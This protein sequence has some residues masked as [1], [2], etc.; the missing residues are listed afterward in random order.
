MQGSPEEYTDKGFG[1]AS[2]QAQPFLSVR[3]MLSESRR[4][5]QSLMEG[6]NAR[7]LKLAAGGGPPPVE[8]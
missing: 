2:S 6:K 5:R 8:P 3:V 7:S 1:S 4:W